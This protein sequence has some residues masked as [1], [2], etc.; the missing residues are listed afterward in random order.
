MLLHR[1][2][3]AAARECGAVVTMEEHSIYGGLGSLVCRVLAENDV[4]V[5]VRV[6]AIPDMYLMSGL[7]EDLLGRAALTPENGAAKMREA[8]EQR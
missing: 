8:L 6:V 2:H 5:P 3:R 1:H 4:R 7:P